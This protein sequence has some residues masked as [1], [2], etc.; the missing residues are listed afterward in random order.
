LIDLAFLFFG[1]S[2]AGLHE[3]ANINTFK[4]GVADRGASIRIPLGVSLEGK[5]Y[6]EDRR[7]AANVDPYI[8]AR[9]LIQTTLK[10]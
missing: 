1:G 8:V 10:D 9:M 4:S 6:L 2:V 5:G 3:T 7:P